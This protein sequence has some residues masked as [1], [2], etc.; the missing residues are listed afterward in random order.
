M[1]PKEFP[2]LDPDLYHT[3]G[4][5]GSPG[6]L[7]R[8]SKK[9]LETRSGWKLTVQFPLYTVSHEDSGQ[10]PSLGL[11]GVSSTLS[12]FWRT[13]QCEVLSARPRHAQGTRK[14]GEGGKKQWGRVRT[15]GVPMQ[16]QSRKEPWTV[17]GSFQ[18]WCMGPR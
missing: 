3:A 5:E 14:R 2:T 1:L 17:S 15:A 6:T 18:R 9:R 8:H 13:K 10:S 16:C 12:G 4:Q 7:L 11:Q